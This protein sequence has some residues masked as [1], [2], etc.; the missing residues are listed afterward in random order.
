M[1]KTS[2]KDHIAACQSSAALEVIKE[3]Q[4]AQPLVVVAH[5]SGRLCNRLWLFANFIGNSCEYGYDLAN[6]AFYEY[7]EHFENLKDDLFC[8]FPPRPGTTSGRYLRR[9]LFELV[10]WPLRAFSTI[11]LVSTPVHSHVDIRRY[12][13]AERAFD[14]RG[15]EWLS[16]LRKRVVFVEGLEFRDWE[17]LVK[18]RREILEFLAPKTSYV[19]AAMMLVG[20]ARAGTECVL[21]GIHMRRGDYKRHKS[22]L[23]FYSIEQYAAKMREV[24]ELFGSPKPV[25]FLVCSDESLHQDA[26]QG[27][28]VA[29][30]S[31]RFMEELLALSQCDMILGPPS[32]FSAWASFYGD[33]P[34]R[35]LFDLAP[36]TPD[37]FIP[38]VERLRRRTDSAAKRGDTLPHSGFL[39]LCQDGSPCQGPGTGV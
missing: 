33:V 2:T 29:F 27:L 32:S 8:R 10:R 30:G 31:G 15:V 13:G 11:R 18:Y 21:C 28:P 24:Q 17:S 38:V 25:R 22:G 26:F 34:L 16:A 20:K 5:P 1:T 39:E 3:A 35:F 4:R 6:I 36:L 37:S 9:L 12:R 23:W 7:A 14:L 19:G